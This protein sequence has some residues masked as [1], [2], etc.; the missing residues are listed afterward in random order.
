MTLAEMHQKPFRPFSPVSTSA[1]VYAMD[2]KTV[3]FKVE[4]FAVSMQFGGMPIPCFLRDQDQ[5]DF[6]WRS[7]LETTLLRDL[8]R[9]FT[10]G[11]DPDFAFGIVKK[12]GKILLEGELPSLKHFSQPARKLRVYLSATQEIFLLRKIVCHEEGV[13]KEVWLFMDSGLAAYIMGTSRGEA[14]TLSL[15]RHF[16][17]NE[18]LSQYEYN[19]K[20]TD[21]IYYKSAHG[22]PVDAI[23]EDVP[24]KIVPSTADVTQARGKI[25]RP[26][27]G[28]M[29][30]LGSK[31]GYLVA[32]VDTFT[33]P[34]KK[35]GIGI[36]PW[37]T[38]S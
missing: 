7:W 20:S 12:M 4:D 29:K 13:G 6:Y 32:P 36:L 38:W 28:A 22:S 35:G 23:F 3:R 31:Y 21:K 34:P 11:Y 1:R 30:K 19:G 24:F 10:R 14:A 18:W 33:P 16:L 27:L 25:E 2:S 15:T 17:W 5:R 8:S 37:S 26:L 9:F